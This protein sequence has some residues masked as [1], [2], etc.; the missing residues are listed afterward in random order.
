MAVSNVAPPHIS[1][2]NR[3]GVQVR[4]RRRRS[5]SMSYVRTRV[6][7]SDWCASRIVVSVNSSRF[8]SRTHSANFSGPSSFSLSRVPGG[9]RRAVRRTRGRG[10]SRQLVLRVDLALH[11]RAAVDDHVAEVAS[12]ASSPGR[13]RGGKRNSSGVSSMNVVVH[14]AGEERRVRDQVFEERDVRLHAADAE[15]AAGRAPSGVTASSKR[16]P[17]GRDLHQQRVVEGRD[18]RAAERRCRRRAGCR[19]PPARAVVREPAVVGDEVV[20]RVFGGDAALDGVAA[21]LDLRPGRRGRSAGSCSLWPWATRIWL[22]TMSMPVTT[23]VTVCS[24]WMRGLTSMK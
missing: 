21:G 6:A 5:A 15:L 11:L 2:Q 7:S 24:T 17:L 10:G 8:C 3:S 9:G 19:S 12:A 22:L 20:L 14:V 13:C 1:R 23:S 18:D 16:R 4:V